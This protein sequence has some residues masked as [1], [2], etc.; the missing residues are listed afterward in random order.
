MGFNNSKANYRIFNTYDNINYC[1]NI[2]NSPLPLTHKNLNY[3]LILSLQIALNDKNGS[4]KITFLEK[5]IVG[6][7]LL[8]LVKMG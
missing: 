6:C 1:V 5:F 7:I 3:E 2:K 4:N 8:V